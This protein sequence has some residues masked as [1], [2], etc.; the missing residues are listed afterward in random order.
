MS[1]FTLCSY[2]VFKLFILAVYHFKTRKK[3][4]FSFFLFLPPT[5]A[6]LAHPASPPH[7]YSDR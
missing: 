6:F 7:A 3:I 5:T 4:T 1:I 2:V